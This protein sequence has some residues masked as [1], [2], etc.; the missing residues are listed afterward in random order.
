MLSGYESVGHCL[1]VAPSINL[2]ESLVR[3]RTVLQILH[4]WM[5]K[6]V[7]ALAERHPANDESTEDLLKL[8]EARYQAVVENQTALI[9]R[10][11]P[12][13]TL[14]F[15]NEAYCRYF[16]RSYDEMLSSSFI[17]TVPEEDQAD[18]LAWLATC[19]VDQP[20]ITH[21][22]RAIRA[23][24]MV[25]WMQWTN[26]AILD[27]NNV[28]VELQLVGCDITEQRHAEK[29]LQDSEE[30]YRRIV[31]TAQE[32]IWLIDLDYR[33]TF[34]NARIT[35]M[36][37]YPTEVMLGKSLLEFMDKAWH[38]VIVANLERCRTG[39]AGQSDCRLKR[40]DGSKIWAL[41]STNPIMD[42]DGRYTGTLL[43]MI[44]IT[45]RKRMEESLRRLSTQDP[46]TGLINRRHFFKRAH[47]EFERSRR[48][49]RPLALLMLDIDHFKHINDT[50]GHPTGDEVLRIVSRIMRDKLRRVDL[51]A[52]YGGEEF[53]MLLPE[54]TLLTAMN[55][56]GR[57]CAA[58]AAE[59]IPTEHGVVSLTASIGVAALTDYADQTF[60]QLL[61]WAD[62]AMYR[63]KQAGRN[64]VQSRVTAD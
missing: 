32:G 39:I 12:S 27:E 60:I 28:L 56:A 43:M 49:G 19:G 7:V 10:L 17:A 6:L 29:A 16:G 63:A 9:C 40:K 14:T 31:Q 11:L 18:I 15:V 44:D 5:A 50:Y 4:R 57:L 61:S 13:G 37:G 62:Q 3:S 20:L 59:P 53:V 64:Q 23:D 54:T 46:L 2:A 47:Q 34:T 41:C 30:R 45:A 33:T 21:E 36:L 24:G 22:H 1:T 55:I 26:Q 51:L 42:G 25:R 58:L 48:Y 35:E 52:R 38:A 8:S